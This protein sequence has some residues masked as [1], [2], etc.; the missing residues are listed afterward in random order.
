MYGT[1]WEDK[2]ALGSSESIRENQYGI[3]MSLTSSKIS[4]S[5]PQCKTYLLY[6]E[7]HQDS[8]SVAAH[9]NWSMAQSDLVSYHSLL[10]NMNIAEYKG[11]LQIDGL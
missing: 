5:R 3:E 6:H 4:K 8:Q 11:M 2:R 1:P 10:Y 9:K 7:I